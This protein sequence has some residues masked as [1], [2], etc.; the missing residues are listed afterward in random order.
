MKK[1]ELICIG[2]AVLCIIGELSVFGLAMAEEDKVIS[3]CLNSYDYGEGPGQDWGFSYEALDERHPTDRVKPLDFGYVGL[4]QD[5]VV[6]LLESPE[7]WRKYWFRFDISPAWST[8]VDI[9]V[10]DLV[11]TY[12]SKDSSQIKDMYIRN[13]RAEHIYHNDLRIFPKSVMVANGVDSYIDDLLKIPAGQRGEHEREP[14]TRQ[15]IMEALFFV[16]DMNEAEIDKY[17]DNTFVSF[18]VLLY[19]EGRLCSNHISMSLDGGKRKVN[20]IENGIAFT[21]NTYRQIY[22]DLANSPE[23]EISLLKQIPDDILQDATLYPGQYAWYEVDI[24]YI[25]DM[26]W[27][28]CAMR[29]LPKTSVSDFWIYHMSYGDGD[30]YWGPT[31]E[32]ENGKRK[33]YGTAVLMKSNG[34]SEEEVEERMRNMEWVVEFS[35]DFAG[36]IYWD[37]DP[38]TGYPGVRFQVDVNMTGIQADIEPRSEDE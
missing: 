37:G 25:K 21:G 3:A 6:G 5:D 14:D 13:V 23:D 28:V 27:G 18:D 30:S 17:I 32:W 34:D 12:E 19:Q 4:T 2:L 10:G 8:S 22:P 26:P 16:G 33:I 20:F 35:T 31:D 7:Q 38:R 1:I 36:L 11:D 9:K 29:I 15:W 24:D